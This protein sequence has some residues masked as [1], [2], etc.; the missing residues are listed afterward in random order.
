M[1]A[2]S[3]THKKNGSFRTTQYFQFDDTTTLHSEQLLVINAPPPLLQGIVSGDGNDVIFT[4]TVYQQMAI[5]GGLQ[6]NKTS[7]LV[8]KMTGRA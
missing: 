7:L 1:F 3:C 8:L 5:L 2:V 6:E 4:V